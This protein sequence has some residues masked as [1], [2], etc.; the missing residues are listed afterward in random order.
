MYGQAFFWSTNCKFSGKGEG[1]YEFLV[2]G[3]FS[4]SDVLFRPLGIKDGEG[5]GEAWPHK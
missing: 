3:E 4:K 1:A 5:V 2:K